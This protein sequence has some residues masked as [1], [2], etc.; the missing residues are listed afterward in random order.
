MP[1]PQ[2]EVFETTRSADQEVVVTDLASVESTRL[3]A[4]EE[5][6]RAGWDDA[7]AA[8]SQSG[9]QLRAD[10]DRNLMALAFTWQEA[11]AHLLGTIEPVMM[12]IIT[13][14]LPALSQET[15]GPIIIEQLMPMLAT[16]ADQPA[17]LHINPAAQEH[18]E[19]A[20]SR[21]TGLPY[22]IVQDPT[23][24]EAQVYLR[25][26]SREVSIDL[27]RVTTTIIKT[28]QDFFTLSQ[29]NPDG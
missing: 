1:L 16:A 5:G 6:Y 8:Q 19:A 18:V 7:I 26:D 9:D 20:L 17:L 22:E 2:L 24:D 13:R 29:E 28:V 12:E 4:W 25:L 21:A 10:L 27:S 23:L 14:V 15:L 3:A 11:R